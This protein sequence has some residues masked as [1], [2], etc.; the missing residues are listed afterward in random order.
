MTA[1]ANTARDTSD[2]RPER[3]AA[4]DGGHLPAIS[5]QG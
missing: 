1:S 5:V 2:K 4:L 3:H